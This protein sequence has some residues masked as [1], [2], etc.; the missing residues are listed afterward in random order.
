MAVELPPVPLAG[1]SAEAASR[2]VSWPI[3]SDLPLLVGVFSYVLALG[4]GNRLLRD[5]DTFFHIAAGRW[6]WAHGAVPATD[7][8]SMTMF[9]QPWVAHE[10]LSELIFAGGYGA[11]GWTGVIAATGV[12]LGATFWLLARALSGVL[13][14]TVVVLVLAASF[15][16]L[17]AHISARPHIL[18]MPLLV[19]WF[20]GLER[21][22]ATR[23]APSYRL[24]PLMT[25]WANLHGGFV[26]GLGLT[27]LYAAEAVVT[28]LDWPA[29]RRAAARW[30]AALAGAGLAALVTPYGW[31][32]PWLAFHFANQTFTLGLVNEW[33]STDFGHFQALEIWLLGLLAV[34]YWFRLRLRLTGLL[35]LLGLVHLALVHARDADFLA[36]IGPILLARPLQQVLPPA[37]LRVPAT[38]ARPRSA[39]VVAMGCAM[40]IATGAAVVAG[41]EPNDQR[42][43][44]T[45]ALA[46]A[47]L[48]H[49]SGPVLNSFN[50]GGYLIFTGQSPFVDGRIELYGDRFMAEYMQAIEGDGTALR[51]ALDTYHVDWTLL[52]PAMPAVAM[53]DHL[54]G[55]ER[56]YADDAAV[57][58]RRLDPGAR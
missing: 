5:P 15:L 14:P 6:I 9:G 23:C 25:L 51:A 16:L 37:P 11:L 57:V 58:H 31:R 50:F 55:W 27:A 2:A 8:F 29:R 45:K 46:A 41:T 1:R 48:A 56:I 52:E 17:A 7:P 43:A 12:A 22:R 39:L 28:Q 20:T 4:L 49:A 18:A 53:L 3:E 36:M 38:T 42:I 30:G 54:P 44:P 24:L 35:I 13:R 10:W 47:A 40:A 32:G 26:I 34:G 21:A 19:A 33:Q